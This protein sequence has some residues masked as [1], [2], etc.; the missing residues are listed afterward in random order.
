MEAG[1]RPGQR[2]DDGLGIGGGQGRDVGD[3]IRRAVELRVFQQHGLGEHDIIGG[4]GSP[5]APGH[6]GRELQRALREVRVVAVLLGEPG[7][8]FA[9]QV[10]RIEEAFAAGLDQAEAA[11]LAIGNERVERVPDVR[12]AL[13]HHQR[14][15]AGRRQ[16]ARSLKTQEGRGPP[17]GEDLGMKADR[18]GGSG[19]GTGEGA[20]GEGSGRAVRSGHG[21]LLSAFVALAGAGRDRAT[22]TTRQC[23]DCRCTD[24]NR[25]SRAG[26]LRGR[27]GQL[28]M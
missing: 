10:V 23:F 8:D 15:L 27:V 21:V 13:D 20:A 2:E 4:I 25:N 9:G 12:L 7:P 11:I 28:A 16:V 18:A 22:T 3:R 1:V 6:T 17:A 5:V 26:R 19:G 24:D 14:L